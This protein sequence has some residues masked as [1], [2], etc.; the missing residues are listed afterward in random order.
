MTT[1][2]GRL[3]LD[4]TVVGGMITVDDSVIVAIETSPSGPG[5]AAGPYIAPGFVDVHVHGGGGHDAMG[6]R[7]ALDGMSRHL[8]RRGVTAFLPPAVTAPL[9]GLRGFA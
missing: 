7:A 5:P 4:D 8:L 3:I 1:V 6:G 9:A 2:T